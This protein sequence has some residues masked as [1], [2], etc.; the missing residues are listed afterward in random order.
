MIIRGDSSR[1]WSGPAIWRR[2]ET[3]FIDADP[4]R[5]CI[6]R[7]RLRTRSSP[8]S[9]PRGHSYSPD[10]NLECGDSRSVFMMTVHQYSLLKLAEECAE[11]SQRALKQMQFGKEES[12]AQGPSTT[13][14]TETNA[15][16][17]RGEVN[18]LLAVLDCLM[19]IGELPEIAPW[20]LLQAKGVKKQ[21]LLKY[22]NYSR[23]LG[24]VEEDSTATPVIRKH[25]PEGKLLNLSC[26]ECKAIQPFRDKVCTVCGWVLGSAISKRA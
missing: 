12:Q 1:S 21:K 4:A 11:V 17:L 9:G 20:E 26:G 16:R 25:T 23:S 13:K 6:D 18:D 15:Q 5:S 3:E 24:K 22:L 8:H 7:Q 2:S 14:I 19:D 10:Q